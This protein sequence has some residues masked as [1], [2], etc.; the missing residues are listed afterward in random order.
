MKSQ[1][2]A[3][4]Q[5]QISFL[6]QR[7]DINFLDVKDC[8]L[9]CIPSTPSMS[10]HV[11]W[12][13]YSVFSLPPVSFSSLFVLSDPSQALAAVSPVCSCR[14]TAVCTGPTA[15]LALQYL[16]HAT[17]GGVGTNCSSWLYQEICKSTK[18][19]LLISVPSPYKQFYH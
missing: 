7:L 10:A 14:P 8:S 13:L 16:G 18:Y 1:Q 19:N 9:F 2:K 17:A 11:T 3:F 4:F 12:C 6:F 15:W 5:R